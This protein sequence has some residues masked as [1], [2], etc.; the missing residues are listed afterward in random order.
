MSNVRGAIG[1]ADLDDFAFGCAAFGTGGGGDVGPSVIAA[2][3]ALQRH[4]DVELVRLEDLDDD[5]LI[6][7]M[8]SIG[9]PTVSAEML[10]SGR[11]SLRIKESVEQ[12]TGVKISAIMAAEIGGANGVDPL[13]WAAELGVPLLDADG[14]GR[15][16]PELPMISMNVAG[17]APGVVTIADALGN[18][19]TVAPIDADWAERWTRALCVA[20]GSTAV[21]A[22]YVMTAREARGAVIERSVSRAVELG[23]RVRRA[24]DPVAEL[25][26]ALDAALVVAGKVADIERMTVDGFVR[27]TMVVH[28][29]GPDAGRQVTVTVQN[30]CLAVQEGAAVIA[31]V[32]DLIG[33]FDAAT[34]EPVPVESIRFGQR[35]TVLAWPCDPLWRTDRGLEIA[36]PAAFGLNVDYRP[37][38]VTHV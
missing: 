26:D 31:T 4:G 24:E 30:E 1:L 3:A 37:V 23:A 29:L 22:D 35:V 7:P 36:G 12:R 13:R 14:M 15:A 20:S 32:P 8:S 6:A 16:F 28:G 10:G 5:A 38:Q 19:G 17:I 2:R 34:A 11:E 33:I 25:I 21:M 27:G 18:T 9:A